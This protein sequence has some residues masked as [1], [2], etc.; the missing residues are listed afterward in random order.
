MK[1]C[2]V[3]SDGSAGMINQAWGVAESL[4]LDIT[5]KKIK[6][7][8]PW[9]S[10]APHFR[11]GLDS[12]LSSTGD[13]LDAPY[14]DVVFAS[15]RR[16]ILP[17]LLIKKKSPATKIVYFQNPKISPNHFDTVICPEH[18]KYTGNNVITTLGA[19]HRVT[20]EKLKTAAYQFASL[21]PDH[22]PVL[23]VIIGGPNKKYSMPDDFADRLILDL[24]RLAHEGWRILMTL[25]RRTPL[26]IA[27]KLKELPDSVYIW[28]GEGDNPYFGL[29]GLADAVLV[30]CDSVS[31]ISEACATPA[32]VYLYKLKG[33]YPKFD[34]FHASVIA[35][36]RA[37]W[38]DGRIKKGSVVPLT[39][40][41]DAA[42]QLKELLCWV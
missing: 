40:T 15:G 42:T 5:F 19:T 39:V 30:T 1:T 29:L 25:S 18:D 32:Q 38:W 22:K 23:S 8:Q 12:C 34:H 6:L 33:S 14:P 17:A 31:M 4:G 24:E 3:I 16:A 36:G 21:N 7:C 11:W 37:Q 35:T 2:W 10:L 9:E 28:D 27:E 20:D 26:S 13:S 41:Q